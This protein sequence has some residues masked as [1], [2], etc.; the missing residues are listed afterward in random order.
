MSREQGDNDRRGAALARETVH[1]N[2]RD[3]ADLE[4]FRAAVAKL[5]AKQKGKAIRLMIEKP[6][7]P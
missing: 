3:Q 1:I 7:T 6:D 5:S 2:E 4:R